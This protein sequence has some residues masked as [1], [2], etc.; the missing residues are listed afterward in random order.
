MITHVERAELWEKLYYGGLHSLY[1]YAQV[2]EDFRP[3]EL[4]F[5]VPKGTIVQVKIRRDACD[6]V[7]IG[8][9]ACKLHDVARFLQ[10]L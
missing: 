10:L 9:K 6:V 2:T 7:Y 5:T 4:D 3:P 8:G 1:M